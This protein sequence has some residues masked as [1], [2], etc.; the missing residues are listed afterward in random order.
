MNLLTLT[1]IEGGAFVGTLALGVTL[2]PRILWLLRGRRT[3]F[4]R[5]LMAT[6]DA[7]TPDD[8]LEYDRIMG[9]IRGGEGGPPQVDVQALQR[10]IYRRWAA[11]E[12]SDEQKD[13]EISE[14]NRTYTFGGSRPFGPTD[15][16]TQA[17]VKAGMDYFRDNPAATIGDIAK[18]LG[19]K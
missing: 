7:L 11:H 17:Q 5:E 6:R 1:A 18:W 3:K 2:G 14:L 10:E 8:V 13:A 9:A 19:E 12:I 4:E 16:L 15:S